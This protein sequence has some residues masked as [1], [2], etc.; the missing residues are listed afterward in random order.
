MRVAKGLLLVPVLESNP[1]VATNH[2]VEKPTRVDRT[3]KRLA[4]KKCGKMEGK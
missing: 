3:S 4:Q 1:F 2:V